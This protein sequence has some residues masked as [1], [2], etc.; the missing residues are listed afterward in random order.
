MR[1]LL[2]IILC[3]FTQTILSQDARR[4]ARLGNQ[5][6]E[7]GNYSE[8]ETN[9]LKSIA[10]GLESNEVEFNLS[11]ALYQQERYDESIELLNNV[12][13]SSSDPNLK[14]DAYF[15]LG[16][17]F[18]QQQKLNEA[19]ESY[20]EALRINSQDEESRYNLSKALSML[21]QQDNQEDNEDQDSDDN[22]Q[23]NPDDSESQES[24]ET[25][26]EEED[27]EKKEGDNSQNNSDNQSEQNQEGQ[28]E[29]DS[30]DLSKQEIDRILEALDREEKRVQEKMKKI[31]MTKSSK[32]TDKDW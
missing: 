31:N 1:V 25:D 20:K 14:A 29:G 10:K 27:S 30:D 4:I 24:G 22:N 9:Y 11:D 16:N 32:K 28:I 19:I 6:Y 18:F 23:E 13:A 8:S 15:N 26:S 17:N 7:N 5:D 3:G 2:F 12:I 21:E